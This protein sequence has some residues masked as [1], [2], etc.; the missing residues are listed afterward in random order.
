MR[1]IYHD[2]MSDEA[3]KRDVRISKA[4][5]WLLRHNAIKEGLTIDDRG[6][7][8]IDQVLKHNRL[9]SLK[10]TREDLERVVANDAKQRYTIEDDTICANQGHSIKS[11]TNENM[12]PFTAENIPQE[13]F[14]GTYRARLPAIYRLGGLSRM[15]RNHV[16][17]TST[18]LR[19]ILGIRGSANVL[20]YLD[21]PKCLAAGLVFYKSIN[22]AI[23]CEGNENGIV[24]VDCFARVVD[25][26]TQ[27]VLKPE[28]VLNLNVNVMFPLSHVC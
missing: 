3:A 27:E 21:V 25:A 19:N 16:H 28:T 15:K 12:A 9:K 6:Y 11:V 14:H 13:I 1:P 26:Q 8:P 5:S 24:P 20:I 10:C 7:A 22:D 23:L 4:C 18:E 17:F 2:P